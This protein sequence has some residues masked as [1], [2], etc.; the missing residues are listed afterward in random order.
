MAGYKLL[1]D[2]KLIDG[3]S[4]MDVIDPATAEILAVCPRGSVAHMDAAV[5]AAKAAFPA[6][7][8]RPITERRTMLEALANAVAAQQNDLAHLLTQEQG[9]P[10]AEATAEI[11]YTCA[12]IRQLACLDLPIKVI[13]DSH[14]RR[15]EQHRRPLG[16]VGAI[17]PWNFPVLTLSFKIPPA[18]LAGNTVVIKPAPTTPLTTLKLGEIMAEIFPA[19]V[20]NIVTD[21]NDLG[22]HLTQHPDVAKISFTGSSATG[23]KVMASAASTVKRLTLELGGNDAAIVLPGADPDIVAPGIFASAFMNAGQVCIAVK[24]AYVHESIYDAVVNRLAKLANSTVV[25]N[26]LRQGATIGPVQNRMQYEKLRAFLADARADGRIVAGGEVED[27]PGYFIRPTIVA[28]ID[29]NSRLVQEEQFGPILPVVKYSDPEDALRRANASPWGLGGSVWGDPE[30]ARDIALRMESGTT[31]VNKHLDFGPTIPSGGAKQ[32][33]IGVEFADEGLA[34]FTQ[35][36]I[37][38]EA[39]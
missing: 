35:I 19:G 16:V 8:C 37:V 31:W 33:G 12:F 25:D 11:I 29:D 24:R 21:L 28:D 30:Q 2:G 15:V 6:W 1:I 26:G 7:A 9:K 5:A 22:E 38:N 23:R 20:V 36:H 32:S 17:I 10:L 39:R 4:T 3:D 14:T 34:E 27:R 13:E 18:L